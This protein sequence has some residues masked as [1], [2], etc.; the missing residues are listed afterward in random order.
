MTVMIVPSYDL[1]FGTRRH[2]DPQGAL[3]LRTCGYR[4]RVQVKD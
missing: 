4:G 3:S 2:A 1:D